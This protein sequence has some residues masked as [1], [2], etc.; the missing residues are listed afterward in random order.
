MKVQDTRNVLHN[1]GSGTTPEATTDPFLS[2]DGVQH[3]I[4]LVID[5]AVGKVRINKSLV[6][7]NKLRT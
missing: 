7:M 5:L 2:T 1:S 4:Q 6:T 3:L